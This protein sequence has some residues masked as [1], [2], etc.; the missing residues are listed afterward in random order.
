MINLDDFRPWIQ[1]LKPD[2]QQWFGLALNHI[3][4]NGFQL[5]E[6][7]SADINCG[8]VLGFCN[9]DCYIDVSRVMTTCEYGTRPGI[10]LMNEMQAYEISISVNTPTDIVR[11]A[12][13]QLHNDTEA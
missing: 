7:R 4:N 10:R 13:A 1:F 8:S 2:H 11:L 3:I 6:T 9:G 5:H 12:I